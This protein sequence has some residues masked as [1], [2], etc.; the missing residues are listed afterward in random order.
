MISKYL[1][2][3]KNEIKAH[4]ELRDIRIALASQLETTQSTMKILKDY[5]EFL[6]NPRASQASSIYKAISKASGIREGDIYDELVSGIDDTETRI[7]GLIKL[8][9]SSTQRVI[10]S[11]SLTTVN[12]NALK[13]ASICDFF[14]STCNVIALTFTHLESLEY[15]KEKAP[16]TLS[17]YIERNL[18]DRHI[19]SLASILKYNR[20]VS[21]EDI[22][23]GI[24]D[25]DDIE[26]TKETLDAAVAMSGNSRIDP[27]GFNYLNI[28]NPRFW[29]F[30]ALKINSEIK[31]WRID[32]R[33]NELKIMEIRAQELAQ[34]KESGTVDMETNKLIERL[35]NAIDDTRYDI[36]EAEDKLG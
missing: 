5:N 8:Y 7:K 27:A 15:R 32:L 24:E 22:V 31:M 9:D 28:I 26:V 6:K 34:L 20:N 19:A 1:L 30:T 13:L 2:N 17:R 33:K 14:S 4:L 18:G 29:A 21:R 16:K 23:K 36:K 35:Q 3:T 10:I 12:A 25:M 11:S